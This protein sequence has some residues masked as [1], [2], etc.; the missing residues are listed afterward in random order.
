MGLVLDE[1]FTVLRFSGMRIAVVSCMNTN[2][3]PLLHFPV[4]YMH[5]GSH[6]VS[7]A[8]GPDDPRYQ[9]LA[10]HEYT[11]AVAVAERFAL[12]NRP[13][14]AWKWQTRAV[15]LKNFLNS[16]SASELHGAK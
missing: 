8:I 15:T 3:A 1:V 11:R 9:S 14:A 10:E 13:S 2:K 4:S 12:S 7:E 5:N 6:V 16:N